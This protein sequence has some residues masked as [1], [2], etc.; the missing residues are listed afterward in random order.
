LYYLAD[1]WGIYDRYKNTDIIIKNHA[2][3]YGCCPSLCA[4]KKAIWKGNWGVP[5]YARKGK[6][7]SKR[8]F[9]YNMKTKRWNE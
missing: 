1:L 7:K 6:L 3:L 4:H 5:T 9:Y 8:L 2:S